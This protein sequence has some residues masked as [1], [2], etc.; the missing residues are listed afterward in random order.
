MRDK[1]KVLFLCTGNSCRSQMAEAILRHVGDE[2]FEAC[3]AGSQPAG[4]IHPL[5]VRTL[6][7][8]DVPLDS[9]ARSK[10]WRE[11]ADDPPDVVIT[12]CDAAAEEVCPVWPDAPLTVH[13]SL[14]D[15]VYYPGTDAERLDFARRV[16]EELKSRIERM[17]TLDWDKLAPDALR[18]ELETLP[19]PG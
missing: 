19:H 9:A 4:F 1:P 3:S 11:F 10:S 16:A 6:E 5:A 17:L 18:R 12:V 7:S 2:R 8:L 14:P 13:W 15:P